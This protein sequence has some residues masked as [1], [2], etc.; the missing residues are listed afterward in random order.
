MRTPPGIAGDA[1]RAEGAGGVA[2]LG[3][4]R[5]P[6]K[7]S[8]SA[9]DGGS[10]GGSARSRSRD[11]AAVAA[12]RKRVAARLLPGS[13]LS[14]CG[15]IEGTTVPIYR[16][17][18]GVYVPTWRCHSWSCPE[19][20]AWRSYQRSEE[21]AALIG[22][23]HEKGWSM[24]F[25]TLTIPHRATQT[26]GEVVDLLLK[27]DRELSH[28]ITQAKAMRSAGVGYAGKFRCLDFTFNPTN[29]DNPTPDRTQIH[30]H[31]H[32]VWFF[33][34]GDIDRVYGSVASRIGKVW[35]DVVSKFC[36]VSS[37]AAH[38]CDVREVVIEADGEEAVRRV[39]MYAANAIA[40]YVS[41]TG[42]EGGKLTPFALLDDPERYGDLYRDWAS[43]IKG[44]R[45][46]VVSRGLR[47]ALGIKPA[48]KDFRAEDL[49]PIGSVSVEPGKV[50]SVGRL[51]RDR[52][53]DALEDGEAVFTLSAGD[54]DISVRLW[55]PSPDKGQQG[56]SWSFSAVIVAASL[57]VLLLTFA[58][59]ASRAPPVASRRFSWRK[60]L[61]LRL[62][63]VV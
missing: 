60:H 3:N 12:R 45:F 19:C 37:S 6:F 58:L 38:G 7:F 34:S 16:T 41:G 10:D 24:L 62:P 35:G 50:A 25:V 43:G 29:P 32:E 44:R 11:R 59:V 46:A 20:A 28:R 48:R 42:K 17:G 52:I 22:S 49:Q 8:T 21:L 51:E 5:E 13:S 2:R 30:A 18:T 56:L 55:S 33:R 27:C 39:S 15:R 36:G 23:A 26:T 53:I 54:T 1:G 9:G 14:R 57:T 61:L 4:N 31:S 47:E 40:G 63:A